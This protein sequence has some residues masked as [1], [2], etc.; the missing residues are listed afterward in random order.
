MAKK[1]QGNQAGGL[2][3]AA[4]NASQK[5]A[6]MSR[7]QGGGVGSGAGGMQQPQ[8]YARN[9]GSPDVQS[10]NQMRPAVMP[11]Q[12]GQLG[13]L[14][15]FNQAMTGG[16]TPARKNGNGMIGNAAAE[17]L[18]GNDMRSMRQKQYN[19]PMMGAMGGNV[20]QGPGDGSA[21]ANAVRA[22]GGDPNSAKAKAD[23][24]YFKGKQGGGKPPTQYM[25]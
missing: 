4:N 13:Q 3:A 23:G 1:Q 17:K 8:Q 11:R 24:Q 20:N 2:G 12:P 22:Q 10:Y 21:W 9:M 7:K 16:N 15:Q 5:Q 25:G 6:A 19:Q 14:G 18:Q